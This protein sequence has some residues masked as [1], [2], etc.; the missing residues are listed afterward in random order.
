MWK[1]SSE[2]LP[3]SSQEIAT[4]NTDAETK[5]VTPTTTLKT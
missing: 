4:K 1:G 3:T 5:T 2:M